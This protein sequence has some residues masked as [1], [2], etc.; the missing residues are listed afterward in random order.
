MRRRHTVLGLLV[1]L[2]VITYLDRVAIAVA[3]PRMQQDLGISP[4]RWGWVL[5]AFVLAYG[6]F[7]IP[8]GAQGDRIGHRRVLTRIVVWWSAFTALTGMVSNYFVLLAT[9]F[10]FGA[11]EAGAF[12]NASGSIGRWFPPTERAR[13]QGFLWA[14]SRLG[15]ALTPVLV[16]PLMA[17]IGWRATFWVF[18][19]AGV[20]WAVCWYAWYREYPTEHAGITHEELAELGVTARPSAPVT[21]P[22]ARLFRSRQLWI[23]MSMYWCYVWGSMFYLTWFPEYL[24]KGRGFSEDQMGVFAALPF[25]AGTAGNLGGGFL[26]DRLSGKYGFAVGR[27]LLGSVCL[28]LSAVLLFTTALVPGKASAVV[29]LTVGFG[30]MD[31]MLPSA[32]AICLDVGRRHAGAVTGAMNTAGQAGGLVCAVL[33]GYLV[34]AYG[35][36]NVPLLVI[37]AMVLVSALLFL[38]ID[39]TRELVSQEE[40]ACVEELLCV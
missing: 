29:F 37:A 3:G 19:A 4:E 9:R 17:G 25:L 2:S 5:G 10:L 34:N 27:R 40:P 8:S 12:P 20:A 39:P 24:M 11:G 21:V 15:G 32:W 33:F 22:W 26:S 36:Y 1:V 13:A 16:V 35:D 23:I 18:G 28:A 7:E 6:I 31:C 38:L 14:A 30:V